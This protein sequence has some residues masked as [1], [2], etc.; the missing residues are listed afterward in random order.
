V[1][2]KME[3]EEEAGVEDDACQHWRRRVCEMGETLT[4]D[5]LKAV[6]EHYFYHKQVFVVG[7][8]V[9]MCGVKQHSASGR[10]KTPAS[11]DR[12][13]D[14]DDPVCLARI[15]IPGFLKNH[16]DLADLETWYNPDAEPGTVQYDRFVRAWTTT[17]TKEW[18]LVFHG[19]PTHNVKSICRNGFDP[20][21]SLGL[22]RTV[23][24][25]CMRAP[26]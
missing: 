10:V 23:A 20:N 1:E 21:L 5:D 6:E 25:N 26:P 24:P 22:R 17:A 3:L 13:I 16:K 9:L 8:K 4:E 15:A 2:V 7:R 18:R 12:C 19:T 14:L 11:G